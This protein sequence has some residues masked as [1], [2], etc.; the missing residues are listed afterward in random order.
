MFTVVAHPHP[1]ATR[2]AGQQTR[3]AL[4]DAAAPLF[5]ER[6]RVQQRPAGLLAGRAG[7]AGMRVSYHG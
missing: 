6:G 2:A 4:L 1:R 3:R 5:T 7:R